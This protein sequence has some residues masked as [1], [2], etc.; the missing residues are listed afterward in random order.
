MKSDQF[1]LQRFVD[2][3]E[4]AYD[5]ALEELRKGRKHSHWIWYVFPQL[6]GL[7]YSATSKF[8]GVAGVAEARAYLAHPVLGNRLLEA[9]RTLLTHRYLKAEHVLGDVDALKFRSCLTL[10][11]LVDPSEKIFTDALEI[12]FG[13]EL[14]ARTIKLLEDWET[15]H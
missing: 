10:F 2:A 8:Y 11:S 15:S 5:V 12:F 9:I 6:K 7:G 1:N 3:Q 4:S 14:D 13:G